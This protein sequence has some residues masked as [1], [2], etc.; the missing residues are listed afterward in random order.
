MLVVRFVPRDVPLRPV[1]AVAAGSAS[2]ALARRLLA[3]TDGELA[4]LRGVA[5]RELILVQGDDLPWVDGV[6]Y[7]GVDP[8]APSL[9]VPTTHA[10]DAPPALVERALTTR[11]H[12]AKPPLAVVDERL[13]VPCAHAR[14][15]S[16]ALLEGRA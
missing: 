10:F 13:V 1:A 9:L 11:F 16:R 6:I 14:P 3:R 2:R 8:D 7:L 12:G 4:A 15:L 5:G